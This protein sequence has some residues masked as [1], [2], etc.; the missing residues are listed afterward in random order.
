MSGH[1]KT[2][3]IYLADGSPTGIRHVEVDNWTGQAIVCPRARIGELSRWTE[4]QRPGLYML[5]GEDPEF[6]RPMVYIGEAE[7]VLTRLKQHVAKKEFWDQVIFFTSKDDNLT[8]AHVKYLESRTVELATKSMRRALDNGTAPP[9]SALPRPDQNAMEVFLNT[10]RML[11]ETLGVSLLEPISHRQPDATTGPAPDNAHDNGKGPLSNIPLYYRLPR[12]G[13]EATGY[14][15]DEGFVVAE[16]SIGSKKVWPSLS[17]SHEQL[18]NDLLTRGDIEESSKHIRFP[19]DVL[20][21]TPSIACRV[22]SGAGAGGRTS[23]KNQ[24]GTT[25]RDLENELAG[26]TSEADTPEE[27][28]D[29]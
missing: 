11:L 24:R 14:V 9:P 1:G 4:S 20:F 3:R 7:N 19:R 5:L 6:S 10:V 12:F 17:P 29:D 15:T 16:G 25:L 18:R 13:V 2:V 22:I 23:W 8:K 21:T 27:N 26:V 28:G